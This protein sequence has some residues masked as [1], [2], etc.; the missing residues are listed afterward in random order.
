MVWVYFLS[1]VTIVHSLK[2]SNNN[3]G[4]CVLFRLFFRLFCMR[5]QSINDEDEDK[6]K[7]KKMNRAQKQIAFYE[8]EDEVSA[9]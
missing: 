9:E 4:V 2:L 1:L 6:Q 8:N 5:C 7:R 3:F